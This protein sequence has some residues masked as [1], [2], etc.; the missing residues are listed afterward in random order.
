MTTKK[1][2]KGSS[3]I[4]LL[5]KALLND[6]DVQLAIGG[7]ISGSLNCRVRQI[8]LKNNNI[9]IFATSETDVIE[10]CFDLNWINAVMIKQPIEDFLPKIL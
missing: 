10:C 2:K 9:E 7:M 4:A 8:D 1:V 3:K 5:Q 6:M